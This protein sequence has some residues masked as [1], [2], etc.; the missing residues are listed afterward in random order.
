[1]CLVWKYYFEVDFYIYFLFG[2]KFVYKKDEVEFDYGEEF[3]GDF[4]GRRSFI[5]MENL[6]YS[7][8]VF[9]WGD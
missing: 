7:Y 8:G 1:M 5:K 9:G 4:E 2:G 3:F 6:R